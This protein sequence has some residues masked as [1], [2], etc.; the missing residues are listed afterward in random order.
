MTKKEAIEQIKWYFEED[1]GINAED[2]T[3]EAVN[4]AIEA[5]LSEVVSEDTQTKTELAHIKA[6]LENMEKRLQGL[7][8]DVLI[9]RSRTG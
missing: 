4:M 3:K 2:I 9:G 7:A 8:N 1:D 6:R 5:L